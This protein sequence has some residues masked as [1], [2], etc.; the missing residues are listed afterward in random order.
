MKAYEME[1]KL[2]QIASLQQGYFTARQAKEVGYKDSR[3]PYH[4][5]KGRWLREG[6]GIYRL[7]N[8]PIGDRSDLVYWSLWSCNQQGEVQGVFSHQTALAI[9]DLSDVMPTKY[10]LSVPKRFRK[11]QPVP[12]NLILHFNQLEP[13]EVLEFEGYKVTTPEKT[14]YDV[15]LDEEISEEFVTQAILDGLNKG[16][17]PK[18]RII[19][20]IKQLS[21]ARAKRICNEIG[22]K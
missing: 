2:Y 22:L 17:V 6:R 3:F 9:H 12:E 5:R 16:L 4:V 8:Y 20:I 18:S 19:Q 7:A 1:R 10:H 14:I 13:N 11:Y 21:S 15:L